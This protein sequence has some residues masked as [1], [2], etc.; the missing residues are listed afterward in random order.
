[1]NITTEQL[2]QVR[3]WAN[4]TDAERATWPRPMP[5]LIQ[6]VVEALDHERVQHE[7]TRVALHGEIDLKQEAYAENERLTTEVVK[8]RESNQD[9]AI[10]RARIAARN[11]QLKEAD[12]KANHWKSRAEKAEA[13][14]ARLPKTA[15]GV[16][17]IPA[18][19]E[20]F[21]FRQDLFPG[22]CTVWGETVTHYGR[23]PQILRLSDCYSTREAALAAKAQEGEKNVRN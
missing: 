7:K 18:I 16:P 1:M 5:L 11:I 9:N 6:M 2:D 15:D 23:T 10:M 3:T 22:S 19:S 20:V 8:L 14:V 13:T 4:M 21:H 12:E 17:V